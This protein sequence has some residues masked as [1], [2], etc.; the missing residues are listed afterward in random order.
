MVVT[1]SLFLHWQLTGGSAHEHT[2]PLGTAADTAAAHKHWCRD[3][4]NMHD[5]KKCTQTLLYSCR[6]HALER[7]PRSDEKT[8]SGP[9]PKPATRTTKQAEA[10]AASVHMYDWHHCLSHTR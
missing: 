1:H 7:S 10:D 5:E 8:G 2:L 9:P 3:T 6:V 4:R